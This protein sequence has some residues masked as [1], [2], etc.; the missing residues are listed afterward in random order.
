MRFFIDTEF[1]EDGKTI[2]LL[3]IALVCEDG[4]EYYAESAEADRDRA[5]HWVQRNVLP[6]LKG[7]TKS[8]KQIADEV[9]IFLR[10]GGRYD[11]AELWGWYAAYDH[12]VLAQLWGPMAMLPNGIP[13]HTNDL[14]TFADREGI[15]KKLR[16]LKLQNPNPHHALED[17]RWI[18]DAYNVIFPGA[19]V[20]APQPNAYV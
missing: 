1:I 19:A 3:S 20:R 15:E 11:K 12:V 6:F 17:A 7:P 5:S 2:D 16:E 4:R 13:Q 10:S 18:R 8:R 9:L 14:R